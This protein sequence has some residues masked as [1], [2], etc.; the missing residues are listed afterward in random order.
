MGLTF[1][2]LITSLAN[3][4]PC[5]GTQLEANFALEN[6]PSVEASLTKHP[7][8]GGTDLLVLLEN[9]KKVKDAPKGNEGQR[10]KCIS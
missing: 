7:R 10:K 2:F 4:R 8:N 9:H 3:N 5:S 1:L 6:L